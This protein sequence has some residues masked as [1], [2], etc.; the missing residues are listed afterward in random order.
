MNE[1]KGYTEKVFEDIKRID[2]NVNEFLYAGKLQKVFEY[3]N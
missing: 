3:K 2:G 1:I